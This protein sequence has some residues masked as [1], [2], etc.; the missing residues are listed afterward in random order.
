MVG[1]VDISRALPSAHEHVDRGVGDREI[2]DW[3]F[4]H[5]ASGIEFCPPRLA[6]VAHQMP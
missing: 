1:G 3:L 2:G 5:A 6:L 4:P